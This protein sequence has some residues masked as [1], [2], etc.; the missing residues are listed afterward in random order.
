MQD[1]HTLKVWHKTSDLVDEVFRV[2]T[3][4]P[5]FI[6]GNL[7]SQ[8][9]RAVVSIAI[10]ISE[11]CGKKGGADFLKSLRQAMGSA[12]E[13]ECCVELSRNQGYLDGPVSAQLL[14]RVIEVK[15]MLVGL[16]KSLG[17]DP[18]S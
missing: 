10:N 3:S 17:Y 15:K 7:L 4:Y 5:R 12:C 14:D 2:T 9:R 16:M 18:Y 6:D 8:V 1:Y 13:V 11:G